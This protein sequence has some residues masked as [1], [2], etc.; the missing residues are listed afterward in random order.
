[1]TKWWKNPEIKKRS[2]RSFLS[3]RVAGLI[4]PLRCVSSLEPIKKATG[5]GLVATPQSRVFDF[6]FATLLGQRGSDSPL[7]CHSLPRSF[8]SCFIKSYQNKR[9]GESNIIIYTVII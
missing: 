1:M 3:V 2:V 5:L 8:K 7:D 9:D 6:G 4:T